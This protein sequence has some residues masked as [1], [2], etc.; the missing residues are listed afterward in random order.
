MLK[1]LNQK[2]TVQ[3]NSAVHTGEDDQPD[4]K[5][6]ARKRRLINDS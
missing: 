2:A 6:R 4:G 1:V 5:N 3:F